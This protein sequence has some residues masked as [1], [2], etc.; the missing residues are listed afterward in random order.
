MLFSQKV[1]HTLR[2]SV[3]LILHLQASKHINTVSIARLKEV[4]HLPKFYE[5]GDVGM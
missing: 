1:N 2:F 4:T 5:P 3:R